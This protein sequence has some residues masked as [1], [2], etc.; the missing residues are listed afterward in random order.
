MNDA[1]LLSIQP[2]WCELIASGRKKV[3]VRKTIP[4]LET[5]FIC[6]IYQTR[7]TW[8]YNIYSRI[9]DWQSKVIGEF[10]C[11]EIY[12][13]TA[14]PF[15]SQKIKSQCTISDEDMVK[16]SCLTL[17]ELYYY[18]S[19]PDTYKWGLFGWHISNL[20]IYDK[21]KDLSEFHIIDTEAIK[22]CEHRE[23]I[24]HN[25]DYTNGALLKGSCI[26]KDKQDWCSRC[27]TKP[28][29]KP[30]QSWCYV[31]KLPFKEE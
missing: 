30:P 12:Q 10:V 1:V 31:N 16:Q 22:H 17:N 7:K 13:H 27:K 23:R 8:V 19:H 14:D 24:Y 4:K 29:T 11:D 28:L 2:K 9:A 21:P 6:Y 26:C 25:P 15:I 20:I 3:E 18:E 5:P